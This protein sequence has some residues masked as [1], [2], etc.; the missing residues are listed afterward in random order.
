[1]QSRKTH[2]KGPAAMSG[3]ASVSKAGR[4]GRGAEG[5]R[6]KINPAAIPRFRNSQKIF[7]RGI[8]G[9]GVG[10]VGAAGPA[11]EGAARGVLPGYRAPMLI[12][13]QPRI[14]LAHV[15][16]DHPVERAPAPCDRRGA[17]YAGFPRF[18]AEAALQRGTQPG[19]V[20]DPGKS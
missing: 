2:K 19:I 6:Q 10:K 11:F 18:Q 9:V 5:A 4:W 16:P 8:G 14:D 12:L 7:S 3:G 1:M 13:M 15:R 17:E 20:G